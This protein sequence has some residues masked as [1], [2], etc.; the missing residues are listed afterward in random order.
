MAGAQ[1]NSKWDSYNGASPLIAL[2]N[3]FHPLTVEMEA[4]IDSLTFP[5]SFPQ[6]QIYYLPDRPQ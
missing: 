3:S 1:E 5:V 6:E 4:L 2:Y